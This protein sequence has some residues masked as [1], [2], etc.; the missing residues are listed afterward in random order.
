[1]ANVV[2]PAF[3]TRPG[4]VLLLAHSPLKP[5]QGIPM[6]G[7]R[8]IGILPMRRLTRIIALANIVL[9]TG[10]TLAAEPTSAQSAFVNTAAQAG[11]MSTEAARL[12]IGVSKT[13]AVREYA[14][15]L[16]HDHERMN[17]ELARIATK[18]GV[19]LPSGLD[20]GHALRLQSLRDAPPQAFDARYFAQV[21]LEH[22]KTVELLQSN[23]LNDDAELA[24]FSSYNLP[25]E[26]EHGRLAAELKAKLPASK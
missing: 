4:F 3:F 21:L 12:A 5:E 24:V 11:L 7:Q 16:L 10:A 1:V 26:K 15:R 22:E 6:Q 9:V 20:T 8:T 25:R 14:Y 13:D 2:T 17:E 19:S 23:L 18:R